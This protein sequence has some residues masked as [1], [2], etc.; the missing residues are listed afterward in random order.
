[1]THPD[2]PAATRHT[3]TEWS[4]R[5]GA[6]NPEQAEVCRNCER[7]SGT[8]ADLNRGTRTGFR[9]HS[10]LPDATDWELAYLASEIR[11]SAR[12]SD[13]PHADL[14]WRLRR[15]F[16]TAEAARADAYL[17]AGIHD[18]G[19]LAEI[20][21]RL[22]DATGDAAWL[23]R[24]LKAAWARLDEAKD[25]LDGGSL[26]ARNHLASAIGYVPYSRR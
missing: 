5:C 1:M 23:V 18:T 19:R 8:C 16:T 9:E 13:D 20:E 11:R 7:A 22:G 2:N 4:C 15:T 17:R 25:R 10:A 14:D 6:R 26:V 3:D 12:Y 24:Q 21:A